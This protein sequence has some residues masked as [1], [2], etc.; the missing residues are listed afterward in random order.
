VKYFLRSAL[1]ELVIAFALGGHFDRSM[2]PIAVCMQN[3][4]QS[5][6]GVW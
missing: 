1:R 5:M 6:Q 3:S 2:L 4:G